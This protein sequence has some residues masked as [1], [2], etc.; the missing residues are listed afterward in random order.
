MRWSWFPL[1]PTL[2]FA[3]GLPTPAGAAGN[4]TDPQ[5]LFLA[6]CGLLMLTGR[7]FGELAQRIGQPAV[8]GQLLAGV[9]LG[10]SILG[11]LW[12]AAETALFPDSGVQKNMIDAVSQLGIL[13]LLLLTGMETDLRLV[14]K[15]GRAATSVSVAGIVVP[16]ACGFALGEALPDTMLPHPEMR[17]VSSLFL[18]TA[19]SISSVKIVAMVVRE[20][21]FM[22]RDLGQVIIAS[23]IID[24]TIGWIIIAITFAVAQHGALDFASLA[25]SIAGVS[26]FL[27]ASLS[28]GGRVVSNLI[29]AVNDNFVS[30]MPVITAILLVMIA[31]AL[32]TQALGVHTVLGAFVAGILVGQSPILTRH[33]EEQLRGLIVA[34]FMPVFFGIAG[35]GANFRILGDPWLLALA[36]GFIA[37]ASIGKFLGA[38]LGALFGGLGR[39][40]ALALALAMNARGSTEVI[41]ATIGLSLGALDQR[42]FTMVVAMAIVTTLIMP[43]TLRWAL[44]RLPPSADEKTRLERETFEAKGFSAHLERF[45]V[46]ADQGANGRLAARLAGLLAGSRQKPLTVI[47]TSRPSGDNIPSPAE[48]ARHSAQK[49]GAVAGNDTGS[50]GALMTTRTAGGELSEV[51]S[52]EAAKGYDLLVIGLDN[53]TDEQ[54]VFAPH[55]SRAAAAF[56]GALGLTLARGTHLQ[57]ATSGDLRVLVGISGNPASRRAAETAIAI[58]N[59]EAMPVTGLYVS[60]TPAVRRWNG[61]LRRR[62]ANDESAILRDFMEMADLYNVKARVIVRSNALVEDGVLE[63]IARGKF[64]LLVLG[65]GRRAGDELFFGNFVKAVLVKRAISIFLLSS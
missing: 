17:I 47:E 48:V 4:A 55:V 42:L 38:G 37:V 16:F 31:M 63:E 1:V 23:A 41:V 58:A 30:D 43:P 18:G 33:I 57:D 51:V 65:V 36:A 20:M 62:L 46:A 12:P 52:H 5:T 59:A 44:A 3:I 7:L 24:D 28:I 40:E 2:I 49:S 29:R 10:P 8:I 25:W 22:R 50:I 11:L 56:D 15:V 13:M 27:F 34:L 53:A 6:Q 14:R 61:L 39:K 54:G 19:L 35:L 64:S 21:N 60:T 9:A 32:M 26:F 45:L